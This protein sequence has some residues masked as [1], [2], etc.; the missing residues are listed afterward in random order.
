MLNLRQQVGRRNKRREPCSES[1]K[2]RVPRPRSE[3][4]EHNEFSDVHPRQTGRNR[5]ELAH[6]RNQSSN[7]R[8]HRPVLVEIGFGIRH[9]SL[10]DQADVAETAVCE[11]VDDWPS[12][13]HRQIV[14]DQRADERAHRCQRHNHVDVYMPLRHGEVGSRRHNDF[15]RERDK[16][17]FNRHKRHN[18]Q[19]SRKRVAYHRYKPIVYFYN[20]KSIFSVNYSAKLIL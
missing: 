13:P 20:H 12:E 19:I 11:P 1:C 8:R 18:E 16:R 5:D 9:F 3:G 6:S 2:H 15:R 7:E 4:C 10:V 17:A 14:V